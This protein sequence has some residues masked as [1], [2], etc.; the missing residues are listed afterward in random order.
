MKW[1]KS[2]EK[3][4]I[5]E[6]PEKLGGPSDGVPSPLQMSGCATDV[7]S[8]LQVCHK[9]SLG[10]SQF[11]RYHEVFF[12]VLNTAILNGLLLCFMGAKYQRCDATLGCF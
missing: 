1:P 3:I 6:G 4:E 8:P 10:P 7:T 9:R 5:G 12:R 2:E 11:H